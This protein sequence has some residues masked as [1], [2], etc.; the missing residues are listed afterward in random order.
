MI[1]DFSPKPHKHKGS[2]LVIIMV[3]ATIFIVTSTYL[4]NYI[5]SFRNFSQDIFYSFSAKQ[6]AETGTEFYTWY[7]NQNPGDY[8]LADEDTT[9][10]AEGFYGPFVRTAKDVQGNSIGTYEIKVFPP[11][12][13]STLVTI[14]STGYTVDKPETKETIQIKLGKESLTKY[15]FLSNDPIWIGEDE[16]VKGKL[17]SNG[18]VRFD[19]T[20][21]GLITSAVPSY[22]PWSE[23]GFSSGTRNGIWSSV[24]TSATIPS[25][26][27][28]PRPLWSY[29]SANIDFAGITLKLSD[30]H[31]LADDTNSLFTPNGSTLGYEV[32]FNANGTVAVY[33]VSRVQNS[34]SF[35]D[36]ENDRW[37][38]ES[39]NIRTKNL[40]NTYNVADKPLLFFEGEVW[41]HGTVNGRITI[42]S[43]VL[44]ETDS[45]N[46]SIR[47]PNNLVYASKTP[48][49]SLGLIAQKDIVVTRDAPTTIEIDGALLAQ[50]GHVYFRNYSSRV[51]KNRITTFGSTMTNKFWTW[52]WVS[53]GN[54]VINGYRFT[55]TTYQQSFLFAPPPHFPTTGE[56][57]RIYYRHL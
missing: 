25:S 40:I 33:R 16:E 17:H 48:N 45:T 51:I 24:W 54:T 41:V 1:F 11:P 3:F 44:P 49:N 15:G 4:I 26:T 18:G 7:L 6:I 14:E 12:E 22:G 19:G 53:S 27:D 21:N 28:D 8:T 35:Y 38:S 29:P 20:G 52:T 34:Y 56:Y 42:V 43:A 31:D 9:L 37:T 46:T 57:D 39:E 32:I 2:A 47:I 55:D 30:L 10:D 13:G 23:H 50:K 5:M 36:Y